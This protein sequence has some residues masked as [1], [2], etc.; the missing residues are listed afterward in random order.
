[1]LYYV[2]LWIRG[3]QNK[4]SIL[5]QIPYVVTCESLLKTSV[6]NVEEK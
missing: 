3:G 2:S 6:Q 4:G 5:F 1:M